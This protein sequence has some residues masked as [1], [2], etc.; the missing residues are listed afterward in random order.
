VKGVTDEQIN[1]AIGK[2]RGFQNINGILCDDVR[3]CPALLP[4][5]A[6]DLNAMREVVLALPADKRVEFVH[7]LAAVCGANLQAGDETDIWEL[8]TATARQWARAYLLIIGKQ[9]VV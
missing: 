6:S 7:T 9:D 8:C 2:A 4:K 3:G 5:Y 1:I